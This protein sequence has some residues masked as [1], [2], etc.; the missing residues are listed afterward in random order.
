MRRGVAL[1]IA[2]LAGSASASEFAVGFNTLS[3]HS[4]PNLETVTPG[5]YFR[6]DG[7]VFGEIGV[8]R[9]SIGFPTVHAAI[10]YSYKAHDWDVSLAAGVSYGYRERKEWYWPDGSAPN[11]YTYGPPKAKLL[12]MP[13]VG[14]KI[15]PEWGV[16]VFAIPAFRNKSDAYCVSLA[17]ERTFGR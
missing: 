6:G 17:I 7:E 15:T 11:F 12:V 8:Y 9:N 3:W 14:Y 4:Q 2:L 13:S 10:G 1:L 16:R 5:I